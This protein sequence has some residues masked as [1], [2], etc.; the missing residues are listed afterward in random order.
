MVRYFINV[1]TVTNV[2][3]SK[4]LYESETLWS[5]GSDSGASSLHDGH[6]VSFGALTLFA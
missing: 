3:L 4:A 5:E 6:G 1:I 2:S